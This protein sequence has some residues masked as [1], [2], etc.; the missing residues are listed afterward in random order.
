MFEIEGTEVCFKEYC[1]N[2]LK[3]DIG[4][5]VLNYVELLL[6]KENKKS[7]IHYRLS[8]IALLGRE[9]WFR[10]FTNK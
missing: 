8:I 4:H 3:K 10:N 5:H 9:I 1:L 2:I 7:L 6:P